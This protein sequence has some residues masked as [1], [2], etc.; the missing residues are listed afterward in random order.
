MYFNGMQ[1]HA[2]RTRKSDFLINKVYDKRGRKPQ[3]RMPE[4]HIIYWY[5]KVINTVTF[6]VVCDN[7]KSMNR[8]RRRVEGIAGCVNMKHGDP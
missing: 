8:S 2:L 5:L 1:W 7:Q 4:S 3:T 6:H